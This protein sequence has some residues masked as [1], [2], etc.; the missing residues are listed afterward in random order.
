MT[1]SPTTTN[2][3]ALA[4]TPLGAPGGWRIT[5]RSANAGMHHRFYVNGRLADW[6]DTVEQ[7]SFLL[8]A[9]D[10]P[11]EVAI[12]AVDR[13]DRAEDLSEAPLGSVRYAGWVHRAVVM[14][15]PDIEPGSQLLL[16]GDHASGQMDETP[17]VRRD[18]WPRWLPRWAWG[19]DLFGLGGFGFD[20]LRA[21]GL[22]RGAF[23]A[24]L[25]GLDTTVDRV[26]AVLNEEGMHQLSLRAATTDGRTADGEPVTMQ[27]APP[28]PPPVAVQAT[29]YDP[30]TQTLTVQLQ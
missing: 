4:A 12:V 29:A 11:A 24:G 6:T 20:G 1:E 8:D 22:G 30:Q 18:A 16:L 26:S 9:A 17:L 27:A 28:P 7:R 2:I 5:F 21:P 10:A 19:E 23:G 14:R 13:L 3:D 25:F 15:T